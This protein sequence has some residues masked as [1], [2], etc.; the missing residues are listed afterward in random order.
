[1]VD[2]VAT[3]IGRFSNAYVESFNRTLKINI[4]QKQLR[5]LLGHVIRKLEENI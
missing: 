1:M 5:N 3:K 2:L 4:L